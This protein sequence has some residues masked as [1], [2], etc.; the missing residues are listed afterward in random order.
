MT[1]EARLRRLLG[2]DHVAWLLAR[3]HGRLELGRPVTERSRS[4]GP[5]M[6]SGAPWSDCSAGAREPARR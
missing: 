4:P 2:G 1:D 3:V 5:A 6:N